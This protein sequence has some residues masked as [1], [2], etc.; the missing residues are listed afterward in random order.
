MHLTADG[1]ETACR[2]L[3]KVRAGSAVAS[4]DHAVPSQCSAS[5]SVVP[6]PFVSLPTAVQLAADGQ[7]TPAKLPPAR[8]GVGTIA[9]AVAA[10]AT[11]V[12][13]ITSPRP[14]L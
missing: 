10:L 6:A 9:H 3:L 1:Q 11:A 2:L 13:Q 14:L 5:V 4:T 12:H 7:E 8:T